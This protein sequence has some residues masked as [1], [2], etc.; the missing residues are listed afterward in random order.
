MRSVEQFAQGILDVANSVIGKAIRVISVERGHDP[1]DYTLV[2]FGGAGA[3]HACDLA[4]AL[5]IPRVLVPCFPGALSALGILRADVAKDLSH[6]I[7]LE[8]RRASQFRGKLLKEF[9]ALVREGHAQMRAEGFAPRSVRI[10]RTLDMRYA[11]QSYELNVPMAGDYV[12]AFHRAHEQRY[13]YSD[14]NRSCEVVNIRA[15]FEGSVP[16]PGLPRL[17]VGG[18]SPKRAVIEKTNVLFSAR[19]YPTA[20]YAR[21]KLQAGNRFPGPAVVMEYSATT[22]IPPLWTGRVDSYGNLILEPRR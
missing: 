2:A 3:L 20:I 9:T 13:G 19:E 17:R 12:A 18:S 10:D 5:E 21:S 1:R 16:K 11:G 6:T 22:A 8:V 4:S 7:R 15:R 14:G